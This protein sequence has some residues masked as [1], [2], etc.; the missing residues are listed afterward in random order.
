MDLQSRDTSIHYCLY[1]G[2]R[3]RPQSAGIELAVSRE[4]SSEASQQKVA[5]KN[6]S[7]IFKQAALKTEGPLPDQPEEISRHLSEHRPGT[8]TIKNSV[9]RIH[10]VLRIIPVTGFEVAKPKSAH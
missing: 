7:S 9:K 1:S 5:R 8:L 10:W 4:K 3:L 2:I 6:A